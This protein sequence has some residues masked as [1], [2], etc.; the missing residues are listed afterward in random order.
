MLPDMQEIEKI[1]LPSY[2]YDESES[3][4]RR[5][6]L[7]Y[8]YSPFYFLNKTVLKIIQGR[9]VSI[10]TV[11]KTIQGRIENYT[12]GSRLCQ[13]RSLASKDTKTHPHGEQ[14][15]LNICGCC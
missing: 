3:Q 9:T 2:V 15:T 13:V 5:S 11:L 10:Q 12:G 4:R 1:M 14:M 6:S 8:S 7:I